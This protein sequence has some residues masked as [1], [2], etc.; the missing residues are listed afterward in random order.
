MRLDLDW[1]NRRVYASRGA[2]RQY[3]SA[4][5]WL[6]AGERSAV[7]QAA[8]RLNGGRVLDIGVGG[9]RTAPLLRQLGGAYVGVDY[10]PDLV[11]VARGRYPDLDLREMDAR[12]L[13]F[14][15]GSFGL[16]VFSYNGID[17][18][19]LPGRAQV[20][21]EVHRVLA[22]G[23]AFV[24]SALNRDGPAFGEPPWIRE[25][26]WRGPAGWLRQA[27]RIALAV[28]NERRNR[29][30]FKDYGDVALGPISGHDFGMVTV[31]TSLATQ[32]RQLEEAG[33]AVEAVLDAEAGQQVAAG[34][35][36]RGASWFYYIARKP[37]EA[38]CEA[39]QAQL[40]AD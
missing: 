3:A 16:V 33:F 30:L 26:H 20:L 34:P 2:V 37:A 24:F 31:F 14:P 27:R 36:G 18:I 38:S 29:A 23:G 8:Q 7:A 39:G 40:A 12:R 25:R 11:V 6:D 21:R 35:D 13:D 22:P 9:G 28:W 5:G 17:S 4:V 10:T 1:V 32:T 15:D 19:D